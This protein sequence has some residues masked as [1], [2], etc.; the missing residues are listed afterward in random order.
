MDHAKGCYKLSNADSLLRIVL[1]RGVLVE[2]PG[3]DGRI[4]KTSEPCTIAQT[5]RAYDRLINY[6]ESIEES[7]RT[8]SSFNRV[9]V[10]V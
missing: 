3:F 4:E 8:M 5:V 7:E 2:S 9:D 6:T 1:V 10:I